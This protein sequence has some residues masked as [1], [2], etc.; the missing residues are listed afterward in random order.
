MSLQ[1]DMVRQSR[2]V[3]LLYCDTISPADFLAENS[4]FGSGSIRN[5]LVHIGNT[6]ELWLGKQALQKDVAFTA[7][8]AVG[9]VGE[10]RSFFRKIDALVTEFLTFF[11]RDYL[12]YL[13]VELNG[14]STK[15]TP[16][17]LFT[18]TISHEFHH[19]GQLLAISRH[20]GYTPI[21]TD[22]MR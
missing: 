7:Y 10:C 3:L 21:D 22:I 9:N 4:A 2:D 20:L 12:A 17:K 14:T 11:A 1:Y 8:E 15:A 19:K 13:H 5:L 18:H 16:L 6:Y